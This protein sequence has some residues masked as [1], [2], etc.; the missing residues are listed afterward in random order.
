MTSSLR[1]QNVNCA[2]HS[3][4]GALVVIHVVIYAKNIDSVDRNFLC[5]KNISQRAATVIRSR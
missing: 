3:E 2:L 1:C 4:N 5:K